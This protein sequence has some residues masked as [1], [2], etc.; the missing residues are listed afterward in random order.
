MQRLLDFQ[1]LIRHPDD[2]KKVDADYVKLY[3]PPST[4]QM[5]GSNSR[6]NQCFTDHD[7]GGQQ[8]FPQPVQLPQPPHTPPA[9]ENMEPAVPGMQSPPNPL[10]HHGTVRQSDRQR[11]RVQRYGSQAYDENVPL[12]GEEDTVQPWWPGYPQGAWH[13]DA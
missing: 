3:H 5:I 10:P 13:E 4:M 12:P 6:W 11:H 1:Q 7:D 8:F 2:I 9:T